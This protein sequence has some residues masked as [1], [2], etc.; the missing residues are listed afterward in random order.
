MKQN[1]EEEAISLDTIAKRIKLLDTILQSAIQ[2][3]LVVKDGKSVIDASPQ[4]VAAI[5]NAQRQINEM[6]YRHMEIRKNLNDN[7][8]S[9]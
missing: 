2:E 4:D 8:D 3:M 5:A 6:S 7:W 1:K 9:Q